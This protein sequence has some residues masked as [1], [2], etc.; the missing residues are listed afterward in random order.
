M[1]NG[2]FAVVDLLVEGLPELANENPIPVRLLQAED[3]FQI[4]EQVGRA[5]FVALSNERENNDRIRARAASSFA[6]SMPLS[7][8]VCVLVCELHRVFLS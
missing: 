2:F 7:A 1:I 6:S 4:L 5:E 3:L 8:A